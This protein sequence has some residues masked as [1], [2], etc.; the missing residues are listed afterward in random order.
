MKAGIKILLI[1][2]M[3]FALTH[4]YIEV[5]GQGRA[6]QSSIKSGHYVPGDVITARKLRDLPVP[7]SNKNYALYQSI[8]KI[9][10]VVIG[11]FTA[12]ERKIT[13]IQDKNADGKVDIVAHLDVDSKKIHFQGKPYE[14]CSA[15]KFR[16][17]KEDIING[18]TKDISPNSE[19]ISYLKELIKDSGNIKKAKFG[20]K[21]TRTDTDEPSRERVSYFFSFRELSGADIAFIVNYYYISSGRISPI[22]NH[23][24]YCSNSKDPFAIEIA[25]RCI[26]KIGKN[27]HT[28]D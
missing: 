24:V 12:D 26:K 5:S 18:N 3:F 21:V 4:I 28:Y 27:Y 2:T 16:K 15:E 1:I 19:G 13:L 11:S 17:Y 22:I 10:N 7:A 9:S 14:Y 20:F 6:I 25:K 23:A 8:D